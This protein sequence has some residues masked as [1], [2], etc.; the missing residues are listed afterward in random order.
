MTTVLSIVKKAN[1]HWNP[2]IFKSVGPASWHMK[3]ASGWEQFKFR[4][5]GMARVGQDESGFIQGPSFVQQGN[6]F[7]WSTDNFTAHSDY[8]LK[9]VAVLQVN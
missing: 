5:Q 1:G 8:A 2:G 9:S 3:S 6:V 7:Q 4:C